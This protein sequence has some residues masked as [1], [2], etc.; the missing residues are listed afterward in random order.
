MGEEYPLCAEHG[1]PGDCTSQD[2]NISSLA[3]H[4]RDLVS[5]ASSMLHEY[6]M[7]INGRCCKTVELPE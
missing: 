7:L 3:I 5:T 6:N 1:G 4:P 2:R